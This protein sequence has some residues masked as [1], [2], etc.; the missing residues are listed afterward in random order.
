VVVIG[1]NP[2]DITTR[3]A[4]WCAGFSNVRPVPAL[5]DEAHIAGFLA[6]Y[7][8]GTRSAS[9]SDLVDVVGVVLERPSVDGCPPSQRCVG[10]R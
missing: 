9:T 7:S 2:R 6:R 1:P 3:N 5:F 8:G 10:S 4:Q